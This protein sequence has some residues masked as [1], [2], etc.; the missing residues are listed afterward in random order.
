M[1]SGSD[2]LVEAESTINDSY[3]TTIPAAIR[4]ALDDALEPGDTVR[5]VISDGELSVEI[6]HEGYGAF[7]DAEPFDGPAW[8]SDAVAE[9]TWMK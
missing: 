1:S 6:I 4:A 8:E 7:K 3:A 5:W 9:S 2:T